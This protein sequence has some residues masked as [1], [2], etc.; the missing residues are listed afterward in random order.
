MDYEKGGT[1]KEYYAEDEVVERDCP[2]CKSRNYL[3]GVSISLKL[4]YCAHHG[5]P[6][7]TSGRRH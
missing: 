2:M 4:M 5:H 6:E 1:E 7:I 3:N